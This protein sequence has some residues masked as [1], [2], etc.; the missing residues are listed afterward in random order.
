VPPA[1]GERIRALLDV[2]V[3]LRQPDG[4]MPSIGDADGGTVLPLGMCGRDDFRATFST[5]AI[6]FDHPEYAWA[7]GELA[8]ETLWLTGP[9]ARTR[10]D[11]MGQRPPAGDPNRV[12]ADGGFVAMRSGWDARAHALIFDT[13]PLGC[14]VSAGHGHAD[15]LSIQCSAF[16]HPY[17]V[18]AGTGCYTGDPDLRDFFRGSAAHSTVMVDGRSHAQ[19]AGPFAWKSRPAA[20]LLQW[21]SNESFAV[22]HAE[23]DGYAALPDAVLHQRRVIFVE[24][25]YWIVIDEIVGSTRHRV[26][27]RFQFGAI[28]VRVEKDGWVRASNDDG[29]GLLLRSFATVPFQLDV[30]AGRRQ[31]TEGWISPDYG[32]VEPAPCVIYTATEQ[33][34]IRMA[35]L[36][37]PA[38]DITKMPGPD[39]IEAVQD[40][41]V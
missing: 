17:L 16:G 29:T 25:R 37:W 27:L 26:E 18:D 10:F 7:A 33:L 6:V 40:H 5:A 12:F 22:A 19:P 41:L 14:H 2:L 34:P 1:I 28:P 38:E 31:P 4:S 24:S 15:L 32:R 30:R 20:R 11:A 8:P 36:L 3:T 35:T 23:H 21:R 39:V 13:G 9:V